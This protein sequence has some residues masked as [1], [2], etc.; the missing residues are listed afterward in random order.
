MNAFQ[1]YSVFVLIFLFLS[2]SPQVF[3]QKKQASETIEIKTTAVCG[4]CKDRIE[5]AM[6]FEKGVKNAHV[7][8]ATKILTVT[9]QAGKTDPAKIRAAVAAVGYD[10]DEVPASPEAYEALPACCRKDVPS[11]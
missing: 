5:K 6:A 9:Y 1:N 8:L 10:A 4:M 7:N 3:G 2:V 11:H